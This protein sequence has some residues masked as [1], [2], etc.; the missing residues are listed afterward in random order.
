AE[1]Q[2]GV[3]ARLL[4]GAFYIRLGDLSA[5][6]F[7]AMAARLDALL[8]R[9]GMDPA[10][11]AIVDLRGNPGGN[12]FGAA[13]FARRLPQVLPGARVAALVDRW[14]F[15]AAL[16]TAALLKHHAGAR[17]VGEEMGDAAAF[18]AEGGIEEMP[19][20]GLSIRHSDGWHDWSTGR[21]DP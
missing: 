20:S 12:C 3:F 21:P 1:A 17:L 5:L 19:L 18:W 16:V 7:R 2:G 6:P 14:T 9:A 13:R 11:G 4:D 15:S 10:H 8:D